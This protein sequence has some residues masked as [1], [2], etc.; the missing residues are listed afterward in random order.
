MLDS[1]LLEILAC[2]LCKGPLRYDKTAQVLI[3]RGDR[4]EFPVRDG[5]P[6]MLESEARVMPSDDPLLE[7]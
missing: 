2:P 1:R 5:V 7:R 6:V 4:L 3:C